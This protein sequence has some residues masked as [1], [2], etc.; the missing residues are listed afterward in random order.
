MGASGSDRTGSHLRRFDASVQHHLDGC[1]KA[2]READKVG[3]HGC[4]R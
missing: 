4:C 3:G 1:H 2:E